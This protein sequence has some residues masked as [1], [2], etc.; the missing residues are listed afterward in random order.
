MEV[1][2]IFLVVFMAVPLGALVVAVLESKNWTPPHDTE[3]D[4]YDEPEDVYLKHEAYN[5]YENQNYKEM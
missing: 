4:Y 1:I 2:G 5:R 3:A